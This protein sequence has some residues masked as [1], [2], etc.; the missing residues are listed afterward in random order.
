MEIPQADPAMPAP[1][2]YFLISPHPIGAV[3]QRA[4]P[5]GEGAG[6]DQARQVAA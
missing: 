1:P 6:K 4:P 2:R 3:E 5:I